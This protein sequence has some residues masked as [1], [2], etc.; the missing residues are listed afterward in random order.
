MTIVIYD[1][2]V[3][4][5]KETLKM[6]TLRNYKKI[7]AFVI[8]TIMLFCLMPAGAAYAGAADPD[9]L[10][11][12]G[13]YD[14]A[15][16]GINSLK[17]RIAALEKI[18]S[19]NVP[20]AEKIPILLYHHLVGDSEMTA[21][22]RQNDM[23]I[24]VEQFSAQMKFLSDNKFYA[25][26]LYELELYLNGD[27]ILPERTVVITFDDGY[28]SNT[29][30]AYPVLK[31]Y[32]FQAAIFLITSTIGERGSGIEKAGWSDLQKCGDVFQY[33]SHSHN[34]H[35]QQRDGK[36]AFVTSGAPE[37]TEDLL[38]S[39]A[40]LST[41]YLAYPYGQTSRVS[42]R[43]MMDAGYRMGFTTVA[44]YAVR[45]VNQIEIPRFTIT[46]NIDIGAF[47]AICFGLAGVVVVEEEPV[48]P[49]M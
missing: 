27:M 5:D 32:G 36:S 40:L 34:L 47:E 4:Y 6:T 42:R 48:E 38:I 23:I 44:D 22:Q 20:N 41:S 30:Y 13:I 29:R 11:T 10:L 17:A 24:S 21:A 18:I 19:L 25:A 14:A 12:P 45:K 16:E 35:V 33:H 26:S 7:T 15:D 43:A 28:R 49:A 1:K 3:I 8:A 31:K 37:I 39:K 2:H 46:P 9:S